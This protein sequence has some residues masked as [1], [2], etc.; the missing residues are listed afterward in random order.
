MKKLGNKA[1]EG[2]VK[3]KD[4][5]VKGEIA[6]SIGRDD[7][8]FEIIEGMRIHIKASSMSSYSA[9]WEAYAAYLVGEETI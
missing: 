1:F 2:C 9:T 6:V 3:L 4:I 5:F 7:R 8:P